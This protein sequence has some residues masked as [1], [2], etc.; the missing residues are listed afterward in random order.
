[1]FLKPGNYLHWS[2]LALL[3]ALNCGSAPPCALAGQEVPQQPLKGNIK[4]DATVAD[5]LLA[6][7]KYAEA[8]T[9]YQRILGE[10]SNNQ[11]AQAGLGMALAK[12]FKLDAA[13]EQFDK[14]IKANPKFAR[15]HIG[16]ATVTMYRLQGSNKVYLDNKANLLK[17]A[18]KEARLAIELEPQSPEA[19]ITLGNC[20]KEQGRLDEAAKCYEET[21]RLDA[22]CA[23]ALTQLASIEL[24]GNKLSEAQDHFEKAIELG[25]S[26]ST[27][28]YGLGCVLLKQGKTGDALK[29]LNTALYL[30][31]NS[32]P[33][34]DALGAA[35][36]AQ[37][38]FVAA[39]REYQ[40]SIRIKPENL[41]AYF[42]IAD[43]HSTRGDLEQSI[44]DLHSALELEPDNPELHLFIAT[45][46][47]GLERLNDAI[48]EFKTV[49][50]FDPNNVSSAL[51]LARASYLKDRKDPSEEYYR[52][53]EFAEALKLVERLAK[54]NPKNS[55]LEMAQDKLRMLSGHAIRFAEIGEPQNLDESLAMYELM[56]ESGHYGNADRLA[57]K[58]VGSADTLKQVFQIAD[59]AY[60]IRDLNNAELAYNRAASMDKN[61][62]RVRLAMSRI[63]RNRDQAVRYTQAASQ[64]AKRKEVAAAIQKYN[65]ALA[66]D[67]RLAQA[68]LELAKLM[69]KQS[70]LTAADLR[71]AAGHY[72][73]YL[74]LV[75]DL[76][77]KE[78]AAIQK[79]T[80]RLDEKAAKIKS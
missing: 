65:E 14:L 72:R 39:V 5:R 63:K 78:R 37:G 79:L 25:S 36:E 15:G 19:Q 47:L 17:E 10:D 71:D 60:L 64:L 6:D 80:T 54:E 46:L 57:T 76:N 24:A 70:Y 35:Y 27:A 73:C 22:R 1:M 52:S 74:E 20:L 31:P 66:C 4:L 28:H 41:K 18:E 49:L 45:Q 38:N 44:T 30:N 43:I 40:E 68:Q 69:Q 51:G 11:A 75:Q 2:A 9:A 16:S 33:V 50:E 62:Q 3:V 12:Q 42:R 67:P 58:M 59:T 8:V 26:S 32:A 61:N 48:T 23:E 7:G 55:E 34:H 21:C 56:F 53:D 77:A 13:Q 29:E